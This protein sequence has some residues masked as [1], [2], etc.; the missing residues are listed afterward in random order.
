[1]THPNYA[2]ILFQLH[3]QFLCSLTDQI[4]HVSLQ[5]IGNEHGDTSSNPGRD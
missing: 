5:G 1:M 4:F 2:L 3:E